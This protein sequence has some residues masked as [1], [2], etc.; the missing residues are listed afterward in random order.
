MCEEAKL[1]AT[2]NPDDLID[3]QGTH[4][5]LNGCLRKLFSGSHKTVL[6]LADLCNLP[7]VI[8]PMQEMT[9]VVNTMSL[10]M[11]DDVNCDG[12]SEAV[13]TMG[14]C[15]SAAIRDLFTAITLDDGDDPVLFH[16]DAAELATTIFKLS[17]ALVDVEP[18]QP[19]CDSSVAFTY[20]N[21]VANDSNDYTEL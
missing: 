16:A 6:A 8:L 5:A 3:T 7:H 12:P 21:F 9:T 10:D 4:I 2:T 11:S 1:Y 15:W 18:L 19:I 20:A 14:C 13:P 17:S